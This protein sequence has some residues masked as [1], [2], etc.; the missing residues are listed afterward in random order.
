MSVK[1]ALAPYRLRAQR[2]VGEPLGS[3]AEVVAH[4]GAVQ[5]QL[6][7]MAMWAIGRRCGAA[8]SDVEVAFERGDF[9]RT[10]VLRPTWHNVL[11]RD[12][13]DLLEL[14]APRIRQA[15]VSNSRRDGLEPESVERWAGLAIDAVRRHGPLTRL[16]VEQHLA[17]AGFARTGNSLAH[18]MIAAELTGEIHNGPL[19]GKRH[20]Y[21]AA[22]LPS[23]GRTPDERLAWLARM[24]ARGHGPFRARD[25]TWLASLTL[26]QA[27]RAIELADLEPVELAGE[28]HYIDQPLSV[29]DVP[30]AMLLTGFDEF[31]S[32]SRDP[33]DYIRV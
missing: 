14:T 5:S 22:D 28:T 12:L 9:V 32:Y 21:R 24:Y 20:T 7:D 4:L 11:A 18:V 15:M 26:A 25:L 2:L 13:K 16:E 8:L 17:T 23:S 30:H 27:R 1:S 19:R 10:H 3:P 29:E 33:D 31:I 6:P